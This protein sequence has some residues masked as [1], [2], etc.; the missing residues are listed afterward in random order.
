MAERRRAPA[1]EAVSDS[2]QRIE[3]L[4]SVSMKLSSTKL[5]SS[6]TVLEMERI[7]IGHTAELPVLTDFSLTVIG[8]ER[9]A[10]VGPNGSGKTTLLDA[11]IGTVRPSIGTVKLHVPTAVFDRMV[12]LINPTESILD[13]FRRINPDADENACRSALVRFMFRADAAL[14]IASNLSGGQL[15]RAGLACVLGGSNPPGMLILDEPTNHLDVDSIE[16]VE[17]GLQEYDGALLVVSHDM[18]FL[19]NIRISRRVELPKRGS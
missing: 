4:Q 17:Q 10:I 16:A 13:N 12:S 19:E 18:T 11:I 2:R 5:P 1:S 6:R 7:T 15:L 3:I 9:I 14:Q 8:P